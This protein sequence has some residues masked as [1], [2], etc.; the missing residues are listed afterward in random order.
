MDFQLDNEQ[1]LLREVSRTMLTS[2]CTPELVRG[3]ASSG[4]DL[5]DNL[6]QR[7]VEIG[8]TGLATPERLGGAGMGLAELCLVAEELGRTVAPGPWIDTA[9]TARSAAEG[10]AP[11]E[12]VHALA[13]GEQR[14]AVVIDRALVHAAGSVDWL[15]TVDPESDSVGLV[16]ATTT[17]LRRRRT[18]DESRSYFAVTERPD[19]TY[20]LDVNA[21]WVR[22]AVAVLVAADALGVGERLLTMTVDYV[23]VR[24]QFGRPIGSFQAVKHRASDM[25]MALRGLR[26]ATYYAALSLDAGSP[27]ATIS[28]SVAKAFA[29][30][31]VPAIAGEALQLHGGIG[32]T[33]EHDLHLYLRRA[34]TDEVLSG[35]ASFHHERV[36]L[37]I[38]GR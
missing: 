17:R 16:D 32:F 24:Q 11:E 15:L 35:D 12:V 34:K 33:W 37:G 38:S 7:G 31:Q 18:I 9:L 21:Q 20:V 10:G 30:E 6:W 26:A 4:R 5:D 2:H 28:A 3:V 23:K 8:W 1:K 25:L 22:D 27:D 14:A 29:A 36:A 19:P 13:S